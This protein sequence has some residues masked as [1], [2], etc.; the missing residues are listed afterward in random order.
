MLYSSPVVNLHKL[1][2]LSAGNNTL[3][4]FLR[5]FSRHFRVV[6]GTMILHSWTQ[7]SGFNETLRFSPTILTRSHRGRNIIW[8]NPPFSS[9]VKTNVGKLFLTLLKKHFPRNHKHHKLFNKNNVKISYGCMPN[10]K[11]VIQNHNANLLSKNT[12]PAA[13][14]SCSCRQKP[15]WPLNKKCLSKSLVYKLAVSQAPS[16][17][18]TLLLWNLWKNFQRMVKQSYCYIKE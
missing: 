18:K 13:A 4:S 6:V 11:S 5:F 14:C 1:F 7:C 3:G 10:M 2:V 16:Q 17:I 15:E 9:N 8:F 12:I